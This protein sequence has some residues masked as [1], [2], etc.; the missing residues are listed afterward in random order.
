MNIINENDALAES[1]LFIR[2]FVL[3]AKDESLSADPKE[4]TKEAIDKFN[5]TFLDIDFITKL[6]DLDIE[7]GF[8]PIF[9]NINGEALSIQN[10]SGGEQQLY[11]RVVSLAIL[12]PFN[13]IILIDEPDLGL[14]PKWQKK[15]ME[16]YRQIGENNQFIIS[17]HSPHILSNINYKD[18]IFLYKENNKIISKV[19][20]EAPLNGDIHSILNEFMHADFTPKKLQ[21][22]HNEYRKY[23]ETN[24]EDS[25]K[26]K[27]VK[28]EILYFESIDSK[29]FKSIDIYKKIN[30]NIQ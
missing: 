28:E 24:D 3:K 13:S 19:P 30:K 17:T 14:H 2:D 15:I 12:K 9:E 6:K 1:E 7:N 22:L 21:D 29:F 18:L 10:L 23:I 27:K 20:E 8:K 26:A 5:K 16:I 25:E 4:R 11:A